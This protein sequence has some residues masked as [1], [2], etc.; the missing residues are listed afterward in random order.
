MDTEDGNWFESDSN[1]AAT[2]PFMFPETSFAAAAEN[3]PKIAT[4]TGIAAGHV[5]DLACGPG[6]YAIPL[7][8]PAM[9]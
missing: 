4:L 6:R 1:W 7:C 5:L 3:I 2:F 9:R 8:K